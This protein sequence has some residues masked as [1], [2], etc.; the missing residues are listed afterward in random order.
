MVIKTL[1]LNDIYFYYNKTKL[2]LNNICVVFSSSIITSILGINGS[3]KT[4]LFKILSG[5]YKPNKGFIIYN[6]V[7]INDNNLINYKYNVGFMPEFLYLYRNMKVKDVLLLL[8]KLKKCENVNIYD[9]LDIVHLNNYSNCKVGDLSKGLKQRLNLG[10][11]IIGNPDIIILDEPT[12]GFDYKSIKVFYSI[13]RQI[14]NLGSIILL[15]NHNLG[16]VYNNVDK[17]LVLSNGNIK[18]NINI[19]FFYFDLNILKYISILINFCEF[20]FI[21]YI[22]N[23]HDFIKINNNF[24]IYGKIL[25]FN[26]FKLL[27]MIINI[28]INILD[29][30]INDINL[31][32]IIN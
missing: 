3:G 26:I 27:N 30:K 25:L 11:A 17:V 12:S 16:E 15:S 19:D 7:L 22:C 14:S 31:E 5:I 20:D 18:Y 24:I 23:E 8:S 32:K 21:Y 4:T 9:I 1:E 13:L 10:Q 28:N 6:D 29:F 2:I